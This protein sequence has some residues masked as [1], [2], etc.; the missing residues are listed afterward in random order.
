MVREFVFLFL[1]IF[2]LASFVVV[3]AQ[4]PISN[5]GHSWSD[6]TN[7]PNDCLPGEV[8][9]LFNGDFSCTS[10]NLD[11][12]SYVPLSSPSIPAPTIFNYLSCSSAPTNWATIDIAPLLS[13][14]MSSPSDLM[15]VK[16]VVVKVKYSEVEIW[17]FGG[18]SAPIYWPVNNLPTGTSAEN[19]IQVANTQNNARGI[20]EVVIP[21]T[22][23]N[24]GGNIQLNLGFNIDV[25]NCPTIIAQAYLTGYFT[26]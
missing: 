18:S 2:I 15:D 8:L 11:S 25:D 24:V 7:L 5:P 19:S 3:I 20:V 6:L 26:N 17:M 1:G 13:S 12:F 14:S 23:V 10:V 16:S 9:T 21:V 22:P 4:T